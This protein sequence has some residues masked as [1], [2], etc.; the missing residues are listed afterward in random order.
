MTNKNNVKIFWNNA[1]CGETLY[2]KGDSD[3]NAYINQSVMRYN[4]EPY[5]I[6]FANF[7][8]SADLSILEIGVGMGADHQKFAENGA[9]LTG[10]DLT[11]RA[12][13]LTKNRFKIFNLHSNLSIG[14]AEKLKFENNTFDLVYSWGVIHHSPNTQSAVNEIHRVLKDEGEAK[15]MI[16]YKFS[17][18][19]YMLWIRYALLKFKP[20][21]TLNYIYSNYLESP[22]TKAYSISEARHLFKDFKNVEI[23]TVLTHGDLLSSEAGQ[24]HKGFLLYIARLIYPRLIIKYFFPKNG[25]FMLISA[26]K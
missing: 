23:K 24:R 8:F 19:G 14:D 2:Y 22:G 21:T 7:E 20:F 9:K 5:I 11:E 16:Y 15:I 1:S 10:I 26:K 17:F 25:L 3:K 18:V 6:D 4:L 12:I 13:E